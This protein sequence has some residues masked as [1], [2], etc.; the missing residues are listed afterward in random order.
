MVESITDVG[1]DVHKD[2]VVVALAEG[3]RGDV[4]DYGR[5]ANTPAALAK[6]VGK[7]A[8]RF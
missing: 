8:G 7:L 3:G 4:P 6:L 5:I 2:D 1:L